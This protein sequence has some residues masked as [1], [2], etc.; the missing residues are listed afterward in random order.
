MFCGNVL[1]EKMLLPCGWKAGKE[2]DLDFL[3]KVIRAQLTSMLSY[4]DADRWTVADMWGPS[5][6]VRRFF[7][8]KKC[9]VARIS[10]PQTQ[11]LRHS[12]YPNFTSLLC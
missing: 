10:Y 11:P 5:P 3:W 7:L 2:G 8:L 9:L 1:G 6:S 4:P 12:N